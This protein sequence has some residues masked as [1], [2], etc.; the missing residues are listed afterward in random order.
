MGLFLASLFLPI[1]CNT[2]ASDSEGG[3]KAALAIEEDN[4]DDDAEVLKKPVLHASLIVLKND[5][6]N[7]ALRTSDKKYPLR[8]PQNLV[9]S[10]S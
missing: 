5:E 10:R 4:D 7:C 3:T 6:N 1:L 2:L 8:F 9:S